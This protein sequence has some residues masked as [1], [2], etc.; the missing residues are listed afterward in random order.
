MAVYSVAQIIRIAKIS[1]YLCSVEI[2][3]QG[4]LGGGIDLELPEKIKNVRDDVEYWY[5]LDSTDDTLRETSNYLYALCGRFAMAAQ[6]VTGGGGSISPTNPSTEMPE[7]IEFVVN[8]TDSPILA[9]GSSLSI[10]QYIGYTNII[11]TRNYQAQTSITTEPQYYT[12]DS[13]T[14]LFTCVGAATEFE[15]F[16]ITPA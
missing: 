13:S 6:G 9:G 2:M 3:K 12:W 11:F 4:L 14:G 5:G 7:K 10:P 16:S 15:I 1:Q 8:T